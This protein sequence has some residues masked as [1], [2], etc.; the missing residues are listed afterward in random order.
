M[1]PGNKKNEFKYNFFNFTQLLRVKR[2]YFKYITA[3][4][5]CPEKLFC[6]KTVY[7]NYYLQCKISIC[8]RIRN[9]ILYI[10]N[11]SSIKRI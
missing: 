5:I 11:V 10:Y 4:R 7:S 2:P 1:G 9:L 6:D 3:V 8:L